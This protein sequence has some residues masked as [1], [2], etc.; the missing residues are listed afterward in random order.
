M[1]IFTNAGFIYI[2]NGSVLVSLILTIHVFI[3]AGIFSFQLICKLIF[4]IN[5]TISTQYLNLF[6]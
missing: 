3:Y 6:F 2:K 1:H 4:G 5:N